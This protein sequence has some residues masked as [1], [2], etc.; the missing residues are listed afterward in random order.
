[1]RVVEAN[2]DGE[3]R[4]RDEGWV[5]AGLWM[6]SRLPGDRDGAAGNSAGSLAS[7][8]GKP[9]TTFFTYKRASVEDFRRRQNL[10]ERTVS[11]VEQIVW[12]VYREG[13]WLGQVV[14]RPYGYGAGYTW[15]AYFSGWR[16]WPE[17]RRMDA[18]DHL[19]MARKPWEKGPTPADN[20]T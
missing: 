2:L 1:M 7:E 13:W 17:R 5:W 14:R 3:E 16:S 20:S 11:N 8:E 6:R 15:Q 9:M 10:P 12:D 19:W 18:A 4:G